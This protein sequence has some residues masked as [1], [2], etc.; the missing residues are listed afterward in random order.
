[1]TLSASSPQAQQW[2][3][4]GGRALVAGSWSEA[5]VALAGGDIAGAPAVRSRR[6]DASGCLVLPGIVDLHGDAFERQLSPRQGVD[7]P[8]AVAIIDN[9]RQ[10]VASGITTAYYGVTLSYEPGL[11]SAAAA[12]D[13]VIGLARAKAGLAACSRVHLRYEV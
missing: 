9:D 11:R 3:I 5:P 4:T 6:L 13:F 1:M 10:V 12:A 2:L 8:F 7:I